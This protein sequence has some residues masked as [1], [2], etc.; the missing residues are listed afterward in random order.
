MVSGH[1]HEGF[2]HPYA[3]EGQLEGWKI[4]G[5]NYPAWLFCIIHQKPCIRNRAYGKGD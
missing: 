3:L 2:I 1:K 5:Y 4:Y